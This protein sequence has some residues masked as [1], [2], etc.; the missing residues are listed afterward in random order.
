MS[1]ENDYRILE[2]YVL[3]PRAPLQTDQYYKYVKPTLEELDAKLE[4]DMDEE[5]FAWL[6]L[7]NEQR[8]KSGLSFVSYDTFEALMD[9]FEKEC[10]FHCM[11][12]NFKPLPPELEHQADCAI[13]LDGSS[14]EE[15]AIL[16]CDM[17]SLSV[18][19]RCYGVVRVPDEIWLCK[20]CLHSPA[21]AAN[22]CLCPCKSGAL[23]RALDGRWA[24]VTC[25]FWI[26]EVSFGDE[27][28]REPIMGIELVSSARWK[29]VCY[30]CSQKNKGACLQCQ[31]S[32]C[33]VAY[34]ATCAQLVG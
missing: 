34:H 7:M 32:N 25:T 24:H 14:N 20:R 13:C 5:D 33:N 17:C 27:T 8:T 4:Y 23:K 26:P 19:Q 31:Y 10:F 28:T 11:S 3:P 2:D 18:H 30:I 6:E 16:F 29:L 21:A 9:R 12:K 15:N 1:I 22:C